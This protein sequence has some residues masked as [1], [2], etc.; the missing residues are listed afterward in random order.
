M[1]NGLKNLIARPFWL[2]S[3]EVP[4]GKVLFLRKGLVW[5]VG[6]SSSQSSW[7]TLVVYEHFQLASLIVAFV[8]N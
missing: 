4:Y 1:T 8:H 6:I 7:H 5:S 2:K 3:T